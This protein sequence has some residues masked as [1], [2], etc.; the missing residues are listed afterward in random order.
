[1]LWEF[2]TFQYLFLFFHIRF[3]NK[4]YRSINDDNC[5]LLDI[6]NNTRFSFLT[7]DNNSNLP[8]QYCRP[9]SY[10]CAISERCWWHVPMWLF[11]SSLMLLFSRIFYDY[12][13][14]GTSKITLINI[15]YTFDKNRVF[16]KLLPRG[17]WRCW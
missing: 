6:R 12:M 16:N 11:C 14:I 8:I 9:P 5:F 1:M 4:Q 2:E 17:E 7:R 3:V 15:V 13:K 10:E